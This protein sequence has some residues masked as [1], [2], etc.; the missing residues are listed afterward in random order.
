M[1]RRRDRRRAGGEVPPLPTLW[2]GLTPPELLRTCRRR[3]APASG[4]KLPPTLTLVS[5]GGGPPVR[6]GS[7]ANL[8]PAPAIAP[9]PAC[10]PRTPDGSASRR[11]GAPLRSDASTEPCRER[12]PGRDCDRP[13]APP[14]PS[15]PSSP[16]SRLAD[17]DRANTGTASRTTPAASSLPAD[18]ARRRR[19]LPRDPTEAP[20]SDPVSPSVLPGGAGTTC[21][22]ASCDMALGS[23]GGCCP[24]R[25]H[26]LTRPHRWYRQQRPAH[27]P[28]HAVTSSPAWPPP[29]AACAVPR[30]SRHA[31]AHRCQAAQSRMAAP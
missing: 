30:S 18:T 16:V 2:L 8:S 10:R 27:E 24:R 31:S 21:A 5:T 4:L 15:A 1:D 14:A 25:S 29:C 9:P 26:S 22:G 19:R 11:T 28:G 17:A 13:L 12:L 3:T 7:G 20:P 23:G 6:T